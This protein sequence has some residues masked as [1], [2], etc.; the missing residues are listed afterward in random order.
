VE[1]EDAYGCILEETIIIPAGDEVEVELRPE[2]NIK[3]GD[4][5]RLDARVNIPLEEIQSIE[6]TPVDS[7]SCSTCLSTFADP[8]RTTTYTIVVTD[9]YGC[10]GEAT[11]IVNVERETEIFIPNVISPN[12]DQVNDLLTVYSNN[13]ESHVIS[14]EIFDRWGEMMFS[15]TDFAPNNSALGWDGT[16]KGK[17]MLPGVFVYV[18]EVE[19][20]PGKVEIFSGDVTIVR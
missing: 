4:S 2:V 10:E 19:L 3:E 1:I 13:P 8:V 20:K 12:D 6:W 15:R 17:A 18:A 11:V 5:T 14:F 16:F 7:L 9:I